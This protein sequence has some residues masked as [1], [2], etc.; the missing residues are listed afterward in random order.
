VIKNILQW[1]VFIVLLAASALAGYRLYLHNQPQIPE[2]SP[3][4]A[5]SADERFRALEKFTLKDPDGTDH[6][7]NQWAGRPQI[8]NYW[9]TW[10]AP[11]RKEVPLLVNLQEAHQ[12]QNLIII[13]LSMDFPE[14]TEKVREFMQAQNVNY[15]V[16]MA[17]DD[18]QAIAEL[19][20]AE[21]FA[22]PVSIFVRADGT[23][24]HTHLGELK[25]PDARKFLDNTL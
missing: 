23:V 15:P 7:L 8:I 17:V 13:G 19:Y 4:E 12:D 16:L 22:L 1:L 9:A 2:Y 11:C 25:E 14:D 5:L 21:N 20:G 24:S 6:T 18:G 3:G 10:C